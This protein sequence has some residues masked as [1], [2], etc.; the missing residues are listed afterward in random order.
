MRKARDEEIFD[1]AQMKVR[2]CFYN[3]IKIDRNLIFLAAALRI[4]NSIGSTW[5]SMCIRLRLYYMF[6]QLR[7][8]IFIQSFWKV[9]RSI[10][11][12]VQKLIQ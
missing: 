10:I 2:A 1:V 11:V 4:L 3:S 12:V 6:E 8:L 7:E 5:N 9:V